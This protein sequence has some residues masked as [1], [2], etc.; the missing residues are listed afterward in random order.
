M[1]QKNKRPINK[2]GTIENKNETRIDCDGTF[3]FQ[4]FGGGLP[5]NA[6]TI[7]GSCRAT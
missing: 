6:S 3:T 7:V 2:N 1:N 4:P 5:V